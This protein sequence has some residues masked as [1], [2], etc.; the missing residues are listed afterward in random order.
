MSCVKKLDVDYIQLKQG[1]VQIP[2][3]MYIRDKKVRRN[4]H[5]CTLNTTS[6]FCFPL[7]GGDAAATGVAVTVASVASIHPTS[8]TVSN[9]TGITVSCNTVLKLAGV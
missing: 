3:F 7:V 2:I 9:I 8:Q 4:K 1:Y 6:A 5:F